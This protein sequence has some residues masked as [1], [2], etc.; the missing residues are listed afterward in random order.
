MTTGLILG[1]LFGAA[2]CTL[3]WAVVPPRPSLAGQV[4]RW[5]KARSLA[6]VEREPG[7][8]RD[9]RDQLG[10]WLA[11]QLTARG[12]S[13]TRLRADLALVDS[14]L[15]KHLVAKL[16]WA[17][18]GAAMPITAG[19]LMVVA[20]VEVPVVIPALAVVVIAVV[21][22]FIP[23]LEVVQQAKDR[24]VDLRRALSCYLDLVAMSLAGGRGVPEALPT[25]ARIGTGWSFDLLRETLEHAQ[26]VDQTPW[27]AFAELGARVQIP[28]LEELGGALQL[29]AH[30]GAKIRTSLAARAASQRRKQLAASEDSV[31]TANQ[32]ILFAGLYLAGGFFLFLLFPAVINVL[33]I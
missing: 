7:A 22:S 16:L 33:S 15:E 30:D 29:V 3:L 23:D 19:A 13:M 17:A 8:E 32:K 6:A 9:W 27:E 14:T 18:A 26:L 25:A 11:R 5:E 12:V 28:E 24:R 10:A 2:V 21:F 4:S 1:A 31:K 20:G